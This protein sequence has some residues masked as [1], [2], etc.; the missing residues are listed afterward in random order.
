ML[1]MKDTI[2]EEDI[3][4]DTT[5]TELEQR[6]TKTEKEKVILNERIKVLEYQ[7]IGILEYVKQEGI[8]VKVNQ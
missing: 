4:I 7:M 6:L 8:L 5:K 2:S 3:L 1:G